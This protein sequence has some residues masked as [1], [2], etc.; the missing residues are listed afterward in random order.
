MLRLIKRFVEYRKDHPFPELDQPLDN[1][2]DFKRTLPAPEGGGSNWWF[3]FATAL[4]TKQKFDLLRAAQ[5]V[6]VEDLTN[7]MAAAIA[8]HYLRWTPEQK[9]AIFDPERKISEE[10]E[11]KIRKA[12]AW[13]CEEPELVKKLIAKGVLPPPAAAGEG[14]GAGAAAGGAGAGDA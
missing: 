12:H 13:A 1:R 5:F 6:G 2:G 14:G 4:G 7:L 9:Q 3:D 10:E 8:T 11:A